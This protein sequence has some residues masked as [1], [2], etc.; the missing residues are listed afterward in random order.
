M[1]SRSARTE[2]QAEGCVKLVTDRRGKLLGGHI[3][4]PGA[5]TMV[6]EVALAVKHGL[7]IKHI[8]GLVHPYPTMSEGV[9]KAA[10]AYYRA[11]L[12]EGARRW[13]ERY[14]SVVRRLGI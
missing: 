7:S 11:K 14:F 3:L 10:D 4:A 1:M 12:T 5:G 8:S 9:R 2:R 6:A 13:L